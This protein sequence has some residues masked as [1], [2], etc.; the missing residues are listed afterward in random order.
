MRKN[1]FFWSFYVNLKVTNTPFLCT[2]SL[3]CIWWW[4]PLCP[5]VPPTDSLIHCRMHHCPFTVCVRLSRKQ[6]HGLLMSSNLAI[7]GLNPTDFYR[8]RDLL[9]RTDLH[10]FP[11]PNDSTRTS[12]RLFGFRVQSLWVYFLY[13]NERVPFAKFCRLTFDVVQCSTGCWPIRLVKPWSVQKVPDVHMGQGCVIILAGSVITMAD[14]WGDGGCRFPRG[15]RMNSWSALRGFTPPPVSRAM[16][17][18]T[19]TSPCLAIMLID[20]YLLIWGSASC[21][22]QYSAGWSGVGTEHSPHFSAG[23]VGVDWGQNSI[24]LGGVEWGGVG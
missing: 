16:T 20:I 21:S 15:P 14:V 7:W 17:T 23:W 13:T 6:N 5:V 3:C 11:K 10:A 2:S 9:L 22:I 8:R 19:T 1:N 12:T 24:L 4:W 18:S